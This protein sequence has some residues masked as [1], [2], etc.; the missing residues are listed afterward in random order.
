M[1]LRHSFAFL[2]LG[3]VFAM[4]VTQTASAST[5]K[6]HH[7]AIIKDCTV[8]HTQ[9]NAVAGNAFVVPDDK[10]CLQCH[11]SYEAIAKRTAGGEEPNPHMSNHYGANL[12]CTACHAEH[13]DSR[14]Y[15]NDCHE[16]RFKKIK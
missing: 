8:C 1:L 5:L 4:G 16:F 12:S 11:G 2:A 13:K 10:A 3:A 9:E 15:C 7:A 14:V 6:P